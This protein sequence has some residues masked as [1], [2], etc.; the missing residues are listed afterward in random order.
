MRRLL[1]E[2]FV[3]LLNAVC[4][5]T[6][7]ELYMLISGNQTAIK[8]IIN[9]LDPTFD[10]SRMCHRCHFSFGRTIEDLKS[11]EET[12][13]LTYHIYDIEYNGNRISKCK[14]ANGAHYASD[15]SGNLLNG[16]VK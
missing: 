5:V 11:Y 13:G 15:G 3:E 10:A 16:C 4:A 6:D 2:S 9:L 8:E 12:Y 1:V 7:I 14:E